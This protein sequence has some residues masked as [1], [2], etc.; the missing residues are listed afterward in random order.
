M[1]TPSMG[2]HFPSTRLGDR[3][4]APVSPTNASATGR[5]QKSA[6]DLLYRTQSKNR[7]VHRDVPLYRQVALMWKWR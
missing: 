2:R 1:G 3:G 7:S 4:H 5:P 6:C